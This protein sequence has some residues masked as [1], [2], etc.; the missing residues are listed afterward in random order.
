MTAGSRDRLLRLLVGLHRRVRNQPYTARAVRPVGDR[1][2]V[3][4]DHGSRV[5]RL[6]PGVQLLRPRNLRDPAVPVERNRSALAL[7]RKFKPDPAAPGEGVD[8]FLRIEINHVQHL[9]ARGRAEVEGPEGWIDHVADPVTDRSVAVGT[10]GA[11]VAGEVHAV[12]A[13]LRGRPLP[14]IPVEL[15]G[16]RLL[17]RA[18]RQFLDPGVDGA[19]GR[20][21]RVHLAD[22]PI[23][24]PLDAFANIAG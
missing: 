14:E 4:D 22:G 18:L 8:M 2:L 5:R 16:N 3:S 9:D 7:R 12:I 6:L 15:P 24:N 1:P 20:V 17:L 13:P 21:D 23:T 19:T 11:P 10:P